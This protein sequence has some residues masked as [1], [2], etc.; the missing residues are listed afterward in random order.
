[1][2]ALTAIKNGLNAVLRPFNVRIDSLTS[3]RRERARIEN[4]VRRGEF[5]DR[6]FPVA[7]GF[8]ST[9]ASEIA[10]LI[11]SNSA[12]F[13]AWMDPRRNAVGF[14]FRNEYFESPDAEVL[15]TMIRRLTPARVI[16]IGSGSSTRI[17]RLAILDGQL[18]TRL[19]SIDPAPRVDVNQVADAVIMQPVEALTPAEIANQL[20]PGDVL[21]IDFSH[22]LKVGGDVSFLYLKVLPQLKAGVV[23]HIHDIFYPFEYPRRWIV[24]NGWLWN[25]QYL[26]AAILL[27]NPT[28]EVLWAGH[29]LQRTMP[30]LLPQF[31]NGMASSLWIR[32]GN[33]SCVES[34]DS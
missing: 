14:S 13:S 15:Y 23:V 9:M 5:D 10:A 12:T 33:S 19:I 22:E 34:L 17:I 29:Y 32:I 3:E 16:E 20:Q 27:N 7:S 25:E 30:Q 31:Q 21:F 1:M 11:E 6:Q 4:V 24:D 26:V 18:H 28:I 2:T 8:H